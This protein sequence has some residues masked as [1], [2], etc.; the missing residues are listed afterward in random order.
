MVVKVQKVGNSVMVTIPQ[1]LVKKASL[2]VGDSVQL[3]F[4]EKHREIR[5][6]RSKR[7]VTKFKDFFGSIHI[8]NFDIKDVNKFLEEEYGR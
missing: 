2:A 1:F 8:P 6:R 7:K 5:I 4:E 3:E